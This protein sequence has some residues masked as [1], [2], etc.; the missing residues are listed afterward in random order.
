MK[1]IR[2]LIAVLMIPLF[3]IACA[4][5]VKTSYITMDSTGVTYNTVMTAVSAGQTTGKITAEQRATI[6]KYGLIFHNTYQVAVNGLIAYKNNPA[7]STQ[8][9]VTLAITALLS[10]WIDLAN[11]INSILP[12]SVPVSSINSISL[13]GKTI[14][15]EKFEIS[16]KKLDTGEISV[17][18]QIG[19][20]ILQY[21]I[22]AVQSLI[23]DM[24]KIT[25]SV[26]DI[27]ALKT[28]IKPPDQY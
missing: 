25:I 13:K 16:I 7:D 9:A 27:Q 24:G 3:L 19:A 17:I 10:N 5:F 22:P 26:E 20:A 6:N 4:T 2:S 18:I 15:G 12:G 14:A 21:L 11:L 23:N 28:L 8:T 1:K